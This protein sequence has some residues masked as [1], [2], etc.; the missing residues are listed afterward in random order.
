MKRLSE[1]LNHTLVKPG[2]KLDKK[3]SSDLR[4][5][6]P[7]PRQ[8]LN[9]L[10]STPLYA[11]ALYLMMNVGIMN[12]TGF[13]FWVVAAR[14]YTT[15]DVGLASAGIAAASILSMLSTLGLEYGL[16]KFLPSS[17]IKGN[18]TVNSCFTI[19]SLVS[20]IL[21]FIFLAGLGLWSPALLIIRQNPAFFAAFVVFTIAFTLRIMIEN[22]Y[23][24]ER[25]AIFAFT[26]GTIYSL[27]RFI[28]LIL[29]APLFHA[30][31]IFSS[32]SIS[33]AIAITCSLFWFLPRARDKFHPLP[34][35][36]WG[37]INRMMRF[38]FANYIVNFL[39]LGFGY[40]LSLVVVN[41]LG[42]EA[43]AY[44]YIAWS[45]GLLL[46]MISMMTSLSLFSE[47]LHNEKQL[48]QDVIRS[49]K[50]I[51][52]LVIPAIVIVFLAGDK[53]LLAFGKA[54]SENA[55]SLLRLLAIAAVPMSINQVY[56]AM[57][58]VRAEMRGVIILGSFIAVSTLVVSWVLLP[59]MGITG[60][61]WAWLACQGVAA[62][63]IG[64][65]LIRN[66]Q[67]AWKVQA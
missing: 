25:K 54:Y 1:L 13:I 41:R 24:A 5:L 8:G 27:L 58:R 3:I 39:T 12:L 53:F 28:P 62:I 66:Y 2:R 59:R 50:L 32:W 21:A 23:V 7:L 22:T 31:G 64:L 60:A 33:L 57:K 61:G 18:V 37:I 52:L 35:L 42:S 19:S 46:G 63:V 38:S 51:G 47:G 67:R 40:I 49:L 11:N 10:F 34:A 36:R 17:D 48:K 14:L 43:N 56:F 26:Q 29:L 45:I 55:T 44:F 20:I 30:F 4:P 9:Q 6:I 15:E 65:T 16:I